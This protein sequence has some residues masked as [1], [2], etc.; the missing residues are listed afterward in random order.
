MKRLLYW[1]FFF[2][3]EAQRLLNLFFGSFTM[4][5]QLCALVMVA[6][7]SGSAFAADQFYPISSVAASTQD[8]DLWPVSNL[9]QGPGTGFNA[10]EPY[11]KIAGGPGGLWVTDAPGGTPPITSK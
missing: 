6:V 9:I 11:E 10:E 1:R 3:S 8:S 7:L 5:R 2:W 4:K